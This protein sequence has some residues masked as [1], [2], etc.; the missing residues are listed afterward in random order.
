MNPNQ[1]FQL[2]GVNLAKTS[3]EQCA[4]IMR[5][6]T[7]DAELLD[8]LFAYAAG[9]IAF[10]VCAVGHRDARNFVVN[11]LDAAMEAQTEAVAAGRVT[12]D[13]LTEA[14]VQ[15]QPPEPAKQAEP[16]DEV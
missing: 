4:A 2:R 10:V 6:A 11:A 8:A 13:E 1:A 3:C 7:T 15:M 5:E 16:R 9:V 12:A 14:A